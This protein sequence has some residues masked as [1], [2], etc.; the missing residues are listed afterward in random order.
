V[1]QTSQ[2]GGP[3]LAG[4]LIGV[5]GLGPVYVLNG[6][7]YLFAMLAL[8][9]VNV[10]ATVVKEG[11]SPWRSFLD[12]LVFVRRKPVITALLGLD[13]CETLFG[14]YR[15][16][17]PIFAD[18][19]GVGVGGYGLLS[20]APGVGSVM[21][22]ALILSLGDMRYK[23]MYTVFGVLG[24]CVALV[25]LALTPWF[26]LALIAAALLGTTNS[27]QAIPR[28]SAIIAISP[29]NLR[30]RV[31]AFRSMLAGGGPPI[32]Y[33]LSGAAAAALGP[34]IAL[35]GGA[36]ICAALVVLIA[37]TRKELRDPYLGSTTGA[38]VLATSPP[39]SPAPPG[40]QGEAGR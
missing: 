19:L 25:M 35:T 30:G 27:V 31:E 7:F 33:T 4:V 9:A 29:D 24:Y 15:A 32:G 28:N 12:G 3:A 34:A 13:L 38:V 36:V 5:V 1:T 23:G 6:A 39:R 37:A 40:G 26:W 10:P 22:A 14:G 16:L 18:N 2:I 20:A 11:E 8:L 17:L 21:G